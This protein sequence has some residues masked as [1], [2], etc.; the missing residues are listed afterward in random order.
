M[1]LVGRRLLVTGGAG[2]VGSALA[3]RLVED[4]EVV[5][6]DDLSSGDRPAV[7]DDATFHEADLTDPAAV[8]DVVTADLDGVFHLAAASKAVDDD[9]PRRQFEANTAITYTLL[10]RM[11]AVGVDRI[12]FTSSSTVYGEAPRPTPE[13]YGPLEPISVYGAAK[14]AEEALCSTYAHTHGFTAW[15][16]RF[17]NVVGPGLRGA[18]IPDF[19]EKLRADPTTLR[20]LGDGRQEKSYLHVEDCV[21][22]MCHVVERA[23]EPVN[24][25]NL[26]TPGTTSVTEIADTVSAVLDLDPDYAF[27][28]GDRGWP[29]D[30]PRMSLDVR[31]LADLGWEPSLSSDDAVRRAAE[32]LAAELE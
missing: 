26:G 8:A 20:I 30:V 9:R 12:A 15:T 5:V 3:D 32:E 25:F 31:K 10:E 11:D 16:F 23:D 24:V 14:L 13:D 7:P 29:G 6:A 19:I 17:A 4:N 21:E 27:T 28:G 22:A 18:V 1:D 2:F